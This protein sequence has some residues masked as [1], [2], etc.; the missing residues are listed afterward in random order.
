MEA[1]DRPLTAEERAWLIRGLQML[2]TGHAFGGGLSTNYHTGEVLPLDPVVDPAPYLSQ[3][4]E[5]R[6]R[7][8]CDCGEPECHTV[9]FQHYVFR[10]SVPLVYSH[11]EDDRLLNIFV[12]KDTGLLA[13]LE[14]I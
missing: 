1:T 6:V 4:D 12:N 5:L 9:H 3:L 7:E 13:E 10:K 11:T 14:I 8:I 2:P